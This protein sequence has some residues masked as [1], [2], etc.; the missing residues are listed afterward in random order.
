MNNL[1]KEYS[2]SEIVKNIK[3]ILEEKYFYIKIKGEITNFKKHPNGHFYFSLKDKDESIINVVMFKWYSD[4]CRVDLKDGVEIVASGKL[5]I[6][7]ERSNYQL[8]AEVIDF[9]SEGNL[10]KIIQERKEKLAKEGLFDISRKKVIPK[11]PKSAGIITAE[12]GAALQD[13]LS[14][15]KERT[16]IKLSL[17]SVLMQG[18]DSSKQI[19]E[20]INYFNKLNEC[21]KPE[22]LVITRGGGSTEDLMTFNDEDLVRCVAS[23]NIPIISAVGHEIDWT[24]IDYASDLRLP[25]PT[26]VAEY[27]TISKREAYENLNKLSIKFFMILLKNNY[28]KEQKLKKIIDNYL[29]SRSGKYLRN[30]HLIELFELK[31]K[32]ILFIIVELYKRH[33]IIFQTINIHNLIKEKLAKNYNKFN[34]LNLRILNYIN[35]F[36]VLIEERTEKIIRLKNQ[37]NKNEKYILEFPDGKIEIKII[38]EI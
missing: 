13:I 29:L 26:S 15:L 11:F 10:L 3:N 19:I 33:E 6:Y 8:I 23:S 35:K 22:V 21:D 12:S 31:L 32:N 14:R 37:I 24:L 28:K 18:K 5:T 1:I 30:Q 2:V 27:L 9:S 7:K 25:T 4:Y 17:Y 16:P 34:L 36:P 38:K 20:A